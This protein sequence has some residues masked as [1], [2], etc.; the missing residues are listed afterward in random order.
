MLGMI[1]SQPLYR[2]LNQNIRKIFVELSIL[3]KNGLSLGIL[4]GYTLSGMVT[5][6]SENS[7]RRSGNLN[8]VL[9][10]TWEARRL[11]WFDTKARLRIGMKDFLT[12]EIF[13]FNL[14]E[15]A[16]RDM[17][18]SKEL[19]GSTIDIQLLDNMAFLDGSLGGVATNQIVFDARNNIPIH[20][21]IRSVLISAGVSKTSIEPVIV[22]NEVRNIPYTLEFQEGTTIYEILKSLIDLYKGYEGFFDTDGIFIMRKIRDRKNDSS[23]YKFGKD[24]SKLSMG[25]VQTFDYSKVKNSIVVNGYKDKYGV[26]VTYR[27]R[28]RYS[29]DDMSS[30]MLINDAIEGDACYVVSENKSFIYNGS[31]WGLL[32]FNIV[33]IFNIENIGL[34]PMVINDGNI[35]NLEQAKAMTEYYMF[36]NSNLGEEVSITTVPVYGLDVNNKITTDEL[37]D[38]LVRSLSVPLGIEETM[39]ILATKIY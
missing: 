20:E 13:W 4:K 32:S 14:G 36:V 2:V 27:C 23:L 22:N 29:R 3:D 11:F 21:A 15:F 39:T 31:T 7:Y 17:S 24:G 6:S 19:N 35:F 38:C 10:S 25:N 34:K 30:L 9:T 16:V 33:P 26:S 5:L 12:N 1:N 28:N 18:I 37:G 8:M